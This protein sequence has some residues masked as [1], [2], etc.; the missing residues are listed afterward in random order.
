[1]KAILGGGSAKCRD[2]GWH[3]HGLYH[4]G[5]P[6][7][8]DSKAL[9]VWGGVASEARRPIRRV[10][11]ARPFKYI[12]QALPVDSGPRE[13]GFDVVKVVLDLVLGVDSNPFE[14]PLQL[15]RIV[16]HHGPAPVRWIKP[17]EHVRKQSCCII[18]LPSHVE[19]ILG[20]VPVVL[21]PLIASHRIE[22]WPIHAPRGENSL[23]LNKKYVS[24]MAAVLEGAP[25]PGL[26]PGSQVSSISR[27]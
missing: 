12:S 5:G 27:L 6:R 10:P 2:A 7:R 17:V 25:H 21:D 19:G 11:D 20:E 18:Q 22:R 13:L 3:G 14:R 8:P 16:V 24:H 26:W 1:M 15:L 9:G 4:L 23:P